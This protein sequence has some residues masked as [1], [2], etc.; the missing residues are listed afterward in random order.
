MKVFETIWKTVKSAFFPKACIS[1][2]E[3]IPNAEYLCNYC[4][5][6]IDVCDS[7]IRCIHCGLP[8]K[9]CEC[10]KRIFRFKGCIAPFENSG[11]AQRA[12]YA[13]KFGRKM[14]AADF[15]A[16]KMALAVIS[17]YR[18]ISFDGVCSVPMSRFKKMR[19]GFNQS[20]ILAEK[21]A[22]LLKIPFYKDMLRCGKSG[23]AQHELG[24]GARFESVRGRYYCRSNNAGRTLLLVD[25]IKTTGATLDE[26]TRV[27]LFSGCS[28]IWC[29][30]GLI[31]K[32]RKTENNTGNRTEKKV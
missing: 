1:C 10:K 4:M 27:L 23:A 12:M 31:T 6:S 19:R 30:T 32:R 22:K 8:K 11:A 9:S 5:A 3:I 29:V 2:G 17:E 14:N 7:D 28:E 25:D 21:L 13:F 20:E 15:F 26:C 18:N 16:E 24:Y